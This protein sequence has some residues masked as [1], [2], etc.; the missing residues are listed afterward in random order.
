M[1]IELVWIGVVLVVALG[2]LV[3]ALIDP[4]MARESQATKT[5]GLPHRDLLLHR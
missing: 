2:V 4:P 1:P 5:D 3:F